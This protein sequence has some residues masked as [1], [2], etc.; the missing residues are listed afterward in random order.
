M[1]L[2]KLI[3]EAIVTTLN[4]DQNKRLIKQAIPRQ[5]NRVKITPKKAG[6]KYVVTAQDVDDDYTI[7]I[8]KVK[9]NT[10]TFGEFTWKVEVGV[11]PHLPKFIVKYSKAF[12]QEKLSS[13]SRE[14]VDAI[15]DSLS[16]LI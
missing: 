12:D 10:K 15:K 16:G 9:A 14:L 1:D 8:T 3:D 13:G 6:V 4:E 5:F 11:L 7:T 2:K